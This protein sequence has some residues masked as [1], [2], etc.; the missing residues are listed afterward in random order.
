MET[1]NKKKNV[2]DILII[3][4]LSNF[5]YIYIKEIKIQISYIQYLKIKR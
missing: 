4:K 1:H 2:Y 5:I 3:N